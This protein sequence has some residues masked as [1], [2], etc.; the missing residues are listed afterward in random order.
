MRKC[1]GGIGLIIGT[2]GHIDHGKTS[3]VRALTGVDCDRLHEEKS[4]GITI[5][6]GFAKTMLSNGLE[7]S[8]IDV[9]GHERFIKHM[10]AG[11]VG[12]QAVLLIVSA[13]EGMMPQTREHL[14][15]IRLLGIEHCIVVITKIDLVD[16]AWLSLVQEQICEELASTCYATSPIVLFSAKTGE[17]KA[18]LVEYISALQVQKRSV[19]MPFR[20]S[21]DRV[22]T[23]KGHGTIVTG[24]ALSGVI[25][26]EYP[27]MLYPKKE[28]VKIKGIQ[29]HNTAQKEGI[30][31]SRTAINIHNIHVK[32]IERGDVI[33][34]ADSLIPSSCWEVYIECLEH[35]PI[36]IKHMQEIHLHHQTKEVLAKV[37]CLTKHTIE[38]GEC[39][40][41]RVYFT[42]PMV[43]VAYDR[44]IL[45]SCSPLRTIAGCTV[46]NPLS[47]KKGMLHRRSPRE[48]YNAL[49]D[50]TERYQ[51]CSHI[52]EEASVCESTQEVI[53]DILRLRIAM[54][55][56]E[57]LSLHELSLLTNISQDEV[58]I[59]VNR[60]IETQDIVAIEDKEGV[61]CIAYA[62]YARYKERILEYIT[63][64]II[65]TPLCDTYPVAQLSTKYPLSPAFLT[66]IIL[67]LAHEGEIT[68]SAEGIALPH[69]TVVLTPKQ[70]YYRDILID[71]Y[72][73][74]KLT[75][76][77]QNEVIA[78][79]DIPEQE[80][81]ALLHY[82]QKESLIV[83]ITD[84]L[85][86]MREEI[87]AL[88]ET[89]RT[90]FMYNE[91]LTL[92]D[93]KQLT[94]GISRKYLVP[95]LEYCDKEKVTMRVGEYR[96]LR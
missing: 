92:A 55:E 12:M 95:L 84:G 87:E 43:A 11:V 61:H 32:D 27:L 63:A 72:R 17:G 28:I 30:A 16:T 31:G 68:I 69:Q 75:P 78:T 39:A 80:C 50:A 88:Y 37:Y 2:A 57:G 62:V 82:L 96:V 47:H 40:L 26:G 64:E 71:C 86:I 52:A 46:V 45:R 73:K 35:S 51:A 6:L 81:S 49:I 21:I 38:P 42:V 1:E 33:A 7:I 60:L 41:A 29:N 58:K 19:T 44:A 65:N 74:G 9:P 13:E 94:G 10:V 34:R 76:P 24:S 93:C 14:D 5:E 23:M 15:I 56:E 25:T 22:F 79:Y 59:Y 83:R 48:L 20:M 67:Q 77:M 54:G 53:Q 91:K 90:F 70:Q 89:L 18:E 3:L 8:I 36:A 85:W 66:H 4:R